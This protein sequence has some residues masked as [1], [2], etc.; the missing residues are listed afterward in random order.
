MTTVFSILIQENL[1]DIA[2]S[3]THCARD[4]T[5]Y[6]TAVSSLNI[7]IINIL[8]FIFDALSSSTKVAFLRDRRLDF[9]RAFQDFS[10]MHF[11]R[12]TDRNKCPLSQVTDKD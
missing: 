6:L 12:F 4:G 9:M 11:I 10:E 1:L 5:A 2:D 3:R 8:A 7:N